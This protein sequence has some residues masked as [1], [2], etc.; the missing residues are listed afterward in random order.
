MLTRENM[1][2]ATMITVT[3]AEAFF[4]FTPS[5]NIGTEIAQLQ[6]VKASLNSRLKKLVLFDS[7]VLPACYCV[8]QECRDG[9]EQSR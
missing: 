4:W 3:P 5:Q 7:L 8:L 1:V 6:K 2:L 9:E